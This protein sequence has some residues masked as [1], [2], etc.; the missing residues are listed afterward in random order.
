LVNAGQTFDMFFFI[1]GSK[2]REEVKFA[3]NVAKCDR[4]LDELLKSGN[5]KITHNIPPL[6][7]LKYVLIASGI[8]LFLM[9]PM[10][11]RFFVDKYNRP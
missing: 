1:A 5:I 10:I 2:N 9:P 7:K 11:V 4:I 3:F 6:N 8:I